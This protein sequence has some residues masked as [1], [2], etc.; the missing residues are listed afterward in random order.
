MKKENN[1]TKETPYSTDNSYSTVER[2]FFMR[3]NNIDNIFQVYNKNAGIKKK[4]ADKKSEGTDEVKLSSKAVDFQ[5]ALKSFK[6]LDD[7]RWEK[8][9]EL[10]AQVKAGTYHIDGEKI[11]E[12]ILADL[13][14]DKRI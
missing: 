8:V 6:E 2:V 9:E 13:N 7:I 3:I 11:A 10:K 1:N 5:H 12:K 14:F 4:D